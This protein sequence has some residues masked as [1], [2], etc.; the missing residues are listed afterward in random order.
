M[1][2]PRPPSEIEKAVA[3][4]L[5]KDAEAFRTYLKERIT[6]AATQALSAWGASNIEER[7]QVGI[8]NAIDAA[9]KE[10]FNVEWGRDLKGRQADR[11]RAM[12]RGHVESYLTRAEADPKKWI[13]PRADKVLA[14]FRQTYRQVFDHEVQQLAQ[15]RAH[16]DV[17][18]ILDEVTGETWKDRF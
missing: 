12:V 14:D 5:S 18:K 7:V 13:S 11:I 4:F 2:E 1:T 15:N 9:F 8:K 10:E 6:Y 3:L 16:E 17:K